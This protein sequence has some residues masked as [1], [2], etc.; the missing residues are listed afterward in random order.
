[1]CHLWLFRW[2]IVETFWL[3]GS[4][5]E[6]LTGV[7]LLRRGMVEMPGCLSHVLLLIPG[8]RETKREREMDQESADGASRSQ[9]IL[10]RWLV[11]PKLNHP[12]RLPPVL[13]LWA[14]FPGRKHEPWLRRFADWGRRMGLERGTCITTLTVSYQGL[15]HN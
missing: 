13:F 5:C 7:G 3:P 10:A 9:K 8:S 1:M 4:W 12:G 11:E 6:P 2:P 15:D 14:A